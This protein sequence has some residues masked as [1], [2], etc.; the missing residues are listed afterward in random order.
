MLAYLSLVF[1]GVI[2]LIIILFGLSSSSTVS[3]VLPMCRTTQKR[4]PV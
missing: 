4:G 2:T 1:L 3:D